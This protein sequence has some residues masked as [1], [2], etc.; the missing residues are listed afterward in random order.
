MKQSQGTVKRI[1]NI[2][3]NLC[4]NNGWAM[5]GASQYNIILRG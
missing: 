2:V 5:Y 1:V 4:L 3:V